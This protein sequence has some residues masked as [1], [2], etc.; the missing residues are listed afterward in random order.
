MPARSIARLGSAALALVASAAIQPLFAQNSD[1]T[2]APAAQAGVTLAPVT[3]E[4][5]APKRDTYRSLVRANA[6]LAYEI[7]QA[8]KKIVKL[9]RHLDSLK[10]VAAEKEESI[11]RTESTTASVRAR[12]L[13]LEARLEALEKRNSATAQVAGSGS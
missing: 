13:E 6:F 12:R 10:A 3:V 5:A 2:A 8:D 7:K 9:E 11:A 4:A 1:S